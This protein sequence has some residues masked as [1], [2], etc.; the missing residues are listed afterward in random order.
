MNNIFSLRKVFYL[1]CFLLGSS[2]SFS[3]KGW[4]T[5]MHGSNTPNAT[6]NFGTQGIT[7]PTNDPPAIYEACEWT[8]QQGRFW[9]FGGIDVNAPFNCYNALWMFD[10]ATG[11]WT[12][13]R[14]ANVINS[15]GNYGVKGVPSVANDPGAR[16][17]APISW[18]DNQNDLWMYAGQ[19]Y[20]VNGNLGTLSDLWK[21]NIASNQ[22]TWMNGSNIIGQAPVWGTM[23]VPA[24]TNFPGARNETS[25]SWID[26]TGN[27][28][29]FGGVS[30][31][32]A[33]NDLWKYD[34][35]SNQWTWMKGTTTGWANGNYGTKGIASAAN[36]PS[37]RNVYAKWKDATGNFWLLGGMD[38][39]GYENDLWK[40]DLASNNWT[41]MRGSNTANSPPVYGTKCVASPINDPPPTYENRACWTDSCG[42]FW[43]LGGRTDSARNDLW[44]YKVQSDK[45]ILAGY[46]GTGVYGTINTP[47]STNLPP[48]RFGSIPFKD[49]NG[50]FWMFGGGFS[51]SGNYYN[52]LWRFVIDTACVGGCAATITPTAGFNGANLSGCAPLTVTF[53]NTST[54]ATSWSWNFGDGNTS[55]A[56]NPVH[57]YTAAGTYTVSQIAF[58]GPNS[59]TLIQPNYVVVFPSP[60]LSVSSQTNVLCNGGS[61]GTA[62]VAAV[63]GSSPYSYVWSNGQSSSAA[64]NLSAGNYSVAVS[65]ANGC[66]STQTVSITQP[67]AISASVTSTPSD[68]AQNTGTASTNANGGT[69]PYSFLWNNSQ[70]TQNISALAAGNYSCTV[71]D[72]NG[73]TKIITTII[74]TTNGPVANAGVNISIQSGSSTTLNASGGTTY[75]WSPTTGLNNSSIANPTANPTSTTIYCVNVFDSSGC[76]DSDCVTVYVTPEPIVCGEFYI[77]NAFSPNNDN[78]NDIFKVY[79]NPLCVTEFKLVIYN[80]WGEN[81][82]ETTDVT[83]GWDGFFRTEISNTAVYAYYC[84]VSFT[85]GNKIFK[86]GNVSLV[87]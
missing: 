60:S 8:D 26:A 58:N 5:W 69:S 71:T 16:T 9:L 47:A 10:P 61:S 17:F 27:L 23:G 35:S 14:G 31:P 87:R 7:A 76:S 52:D 22:W 15:Q 41:W 38:G 1:A 42:N 56:Q 75:S 70:T 39:N 81:V 82:F 51:I 3:Q 77:P 37:A 66:S 43:F 85:N 67:S 11:M 24:P 62:T 83:K 68:C 25:A 50:N 45:W 80:R 21:Y 86:K 6:G 34:V 18:V 79:V 29:F 28:W 63:G 78:E 73:C 64:S 48:A 53:T 44:C 74:S 59:D 13:M 12:W 57:T 40:Y 32:G 19:G 54:N 20:D 30:T 4:W 65:D 49:K 2:P 46:K 33:L 84:N 55:T 36:L 72:A